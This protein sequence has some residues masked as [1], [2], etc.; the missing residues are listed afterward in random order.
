VSGAQAEQVYE[1]TLDDVLRIVRGRVVPLIEGSGEQ[2]VRALAQLPSFT[3]VGPLGLAGPQSIGFLANPKYRTEVRQSKAGAVLCSVDDAAALVTEFLEVQATEPARKFPVL[4]ECRNPYAAFARISQVFFRPRHGFSGQSAQ[5]Y[6]DESAVVSEHATIF[7]FVYIGPGAHVAAGCVL[8]PGAFVGAGS[9]LAEDCILY[10]NSV[11]REGCRLGK[12]CILNPGAVVGGDGFG[13][14]PDG[15]ENVKIPHIGGVSLGD[16]VEI[17]SNASVDRGTL[18]DTAIG[19]QT[20][21]DSLVQVAHNV[22]V[23]RACFMAALSGIAGSTKLGDRVT[24]GGRVAISGHLQIAGGVTLLGACTVS[25]SL[26]QPGMYN[27]NPAMPNREFL[28]HEATLRRLVQRHEDE[29]QKI[30]GPVTGSN[31]INRKGEEDS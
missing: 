18:G 4:I 16:E 7:P 27:G 20:K 19:S 23:G 28:R 13:F 25:K 30:K 1:L 29:R 9:E 21:V 6:V 3:G 12:G 24:V 5:A 8:Y 15:D 2:G 26:L 14:A 22:T 31:D 17:G 11:I 10:P